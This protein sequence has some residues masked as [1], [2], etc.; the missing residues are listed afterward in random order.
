LFFA[1]AA[2]DRAGDA[3]TK[4]ELIASHGGMN[5]NEDFATKLKN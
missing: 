4:E 2:R 3:W 1:Y 5:K